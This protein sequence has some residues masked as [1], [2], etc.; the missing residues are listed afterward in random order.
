MFSV[1]RKKALVAKIEAGHRRVHGVHDE[2]CSIVDKLEEI[3][4]TRTGIYGNWLVR[5]ILNGNFHPWED[6]NTVN[7]TLQFFEEVKTG[8]LNKDINSYDLHEL[9]RVVGQYQDNITKSNPQAVYLNR[10]REGRTSSKDK[11]ML[12]FDDEDYAVIRVV[13]KETAAI[14]AQNTSWCIK[15][16]TWADKY[17]KYAPLYF[18][19]KEG[20]PLALLYM[21]SSYTFRNMVADAVYR[22]KEA[23]F[24]GIEDYYEIVDVFAEDQEDSLEVP[25]YDLRDTA[26]GR[27]RPTNEEKGI[28][29]DIQE[30]INEDDSFEPEIKSKLGEGEIVIAFVRTFRDISGANLSGLEFNK[31]DT[32]F[33]DRQLKD[34][35]FSETDF[36][37][38]DF[39]GSILLRADFSSAGCQQANVNN[40]TADYTIFDYADFYRA[41]FMYTSLFRASF[42][43]TDLRF[44]NFNGAD[45]TDVNL[46]G[47][48]VEGADFRRANLTG[49]DFSVTIG[50][51]RAIF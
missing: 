36:D 14:L 7:E 48:L 42:V 10:L 12:V 5:E 15:E 25:T 51:D 8:L 13:Q 32:E 47:A 17:L 22:V 43:G 1:A 24:P 46:N 45:L 38:P 23:R 39:S 28:L 35:N 26:D 3:D 34:V 16:D 19:L 9:R 6:A 4:P 30:V 33:H 27:F 21:V 29:E 44:V 40:V 50:A 41:S 20:K 49:V 2:A 18:M 11:S 31:Y 37:Q